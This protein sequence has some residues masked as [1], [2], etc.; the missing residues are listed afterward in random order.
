MHNALLP[1]SRGVGVNLFCLIKGLKTGVT[2]HEIDENFDEGNIILKKEIS[3]IKN[4]TSRTF[5]L[6]LLEETNFYLLKIGI[7]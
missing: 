3:F 1:H 7:K 4:E 6:R 2:I 5:Y